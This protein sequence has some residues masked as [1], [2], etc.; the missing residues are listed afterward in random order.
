MKPL[1][2]SL[3]L[4]SVFSVIS[5]K[6]FLDAKTDKKLVIPSTIQDAQAILDNYSTLNTFYYPLGAQSDDDYFLLDTYYNSTDENSRNYYVWYKD[7]VINNAWN[8][9][10]QVIVN[11]NI[12]LETLAK[13]Q[14]QQNTVND[15][16][17]AKG[18]ALFFRAYAHYQ[19]AQY[20]A[21]PYDKNTASEKLGIPLRLT[22]DINEPT[23]RSSLEETWQQIIKDY[24]EAASLL[25]VTTSLVSRPSR[26][27]AYA[28]LARTYLDM[29][30]YISAGK[31]ADSSLQLYN[32]LLDYNT[33][34]PAASAPFSRFNAEVLFNTVMLGPG[35]LLPNNG[36]IDSLLYISY[37]LN[38]L[39]R[40]LFF[41]SNGT[42]T[43]GFKG[44]YDGTSNNAANFNGLAVDEVYL[45]RAECNARMGKVAAAMDDLNTLLIKRWKSGTFIPYTA[46]DAEDALNKILQER[47]K[48]LLFR[49]IRWFD[50]RRLN[51][52]PRFAKTLMRK[53]NG[54]LFELPP[55][56]KRYTFFIPEN[57]IALTGIQQNE[58][59]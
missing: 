46:L 22:S 3:V 52:D 51:K 19:V 2:I 49:G 43:Y 33:L 34:N 17:Q 4:L 11:A 16:K 57:V 18:A 36:R 32:T 27:A 8:Y 10:Y 55:N 37:D 26:L 6:K 14:P 41:Q 53:V 39:R 1:F 5:C 44:N 24:K 12:A 23:M 42:G 54:Q 28:A 48:E 13:I 15:W 35:A 59:Y 45:V 47:R 7:A 30:D 31:Y 25:P 50:L 29:D 58:R 56:D 38:D 21:S 9:M 40:S 20:Y